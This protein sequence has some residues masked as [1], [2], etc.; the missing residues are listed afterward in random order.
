MHLGF[1]PKRARDEAN[2]WHAHGRSIDMETLTDELDYLNREG[3]N[4][5]VHTDGDF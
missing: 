2:E 3:L 5:F 4:S 1:T